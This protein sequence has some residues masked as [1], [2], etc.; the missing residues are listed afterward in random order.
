MESVGRAVKEAAPKQIVTNHLWGSAT[1]SEYF[2]FNDGF[3][4]WMTFYLFQSGHNT[5]TAAVQ[6]A[7]EL[8][9][10]LEASSSPAMPSI[11]GE[12][13]YDAVSYDPNHRSRAAQS[14]PRSGPSRAPREEPRRSSSADAHHPW[15]RASSG[16]S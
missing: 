9:L 7:R 5:L 12:A 3:D 13:P 8:P 1:T 2:S 10:D 16:L 4:P 11:N 15:G 14:G 6:R